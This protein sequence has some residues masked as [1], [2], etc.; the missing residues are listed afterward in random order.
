VIL[1]SDGVPDIPS[2]VLDAAQDIKDLSHVLYTIG[3]SPPSSGK[4]L[5]EDCQNGGYYDVT[6]I[7]DLDG[8]FDDIGDDI[9]HRFGALTAYSTGSGAGIGGAANGGQS[10]ANAGRITIRGATVKAYSNGYGA[11]IGGGRGGAGGYFLLDGG[12]VEAG[13][14]PPGY[15]DDAR[16]AYG[17]GVGGGQG[18]AGGSIAV[19]N[20]KLLA[21]SADTGAGYG[22]GVGSGSNGANGGSVAIVRTDDLQAYSS[23][24]G[25][26]YGAGIGGGFQSPCGTVVITDHGKVV[27]KSAGSG[28]K[29]GADIG[30]GAENGNHGNQ[31]ILTNSIGG[32]YLVGHVTLSDA[33]ESYTVSAADKLIIPAGASLTI[34]AGVTLVNDGIIENY[35]ALNN[36][37]KL[38][39]NG[40]IDNFAVLRNNGQFIRNPGSF[41][42]DD[43]AVGPP[44]TP[45]DD[46]PSWSTPGESSWRELRAADDALWTRYSLSG[47]AASLYLTPDKAMEIVACSEDGT[48]DIDLTDVGGLTE[49]SLPKAALAYFAGE[50]LDVEFRMPLGAVRLNRAA[51]TDIAKQGDGTQ[52]YIRLLR[53]QTGALNAARQASLQAGDVVYELALDVDGQN[54]SGFNGAVT[55][56]VPYT[57][58]LP[59]GAWYLD[60]NGRR[61]K[62]ESAYENGF[63]RFTTRRV[64]LF[65]VGRAGASAEE[66]GGLPW[67]YVN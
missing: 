43:P 27:A 4:T 40:R 48:A 5:L 44:V 52:L 35:G 65:A 58:A 23:R 59:A 47:S 41:F 67:Y 17:A 15:G 51:A 1:L 22:A 46:T 3:V 66:A 13:G 62:A 26:G 54:L 14:V 37:S 50:G 61:E 31:L 39:N 25:A 12:T 20:G 29:H 49:V 32:D 36:N 45:A 34:P 55:V 57:E 33:I 24:S 8:V 19:Q 30:A 11:G 2:D 64:A 6:N 21:Y 63:L 16:D 56:T 42:N 28:A 53:V 60:E 9:L 18:G 38:V 10:D 7:S